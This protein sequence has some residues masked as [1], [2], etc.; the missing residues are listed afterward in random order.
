MVSLILHTDLAV[1]L[2]TGPEGP[3][4][5]PYRQGGPPGARRRGWTG[6]RPARALPTRPR[7]PRGPHH[8][9][10]RR[11]P[12]AR[13]RLGRAPE[14]PER[15]VARVGCPAHAVRPRPVALPVHGP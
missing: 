6:R 15:P 11:P 2:R 13:A 8:P 1:L 10:V 4:P 9:G 7:G 12:R 5:L 3:R 14:P